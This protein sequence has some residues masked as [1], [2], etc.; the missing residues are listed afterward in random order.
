MNEVVRLNEPNV[1]F[2]ESEGIVVVINLVSGLYFRLDQAS[3]NLWGILASGP[4]VEEFFAGCRNADEL[5]GQWPEIRSTLLLH[6]LVVF[7]NLEKA[8]SRGAISWVFEGFSIEPFTDLEDILKLD[9]I[10]EVDPGRGWPHPRS[11]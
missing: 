3:A 1:I 8:P 2:D 11:E 10:H 4:S 7:E 9:P 6:G 5:R